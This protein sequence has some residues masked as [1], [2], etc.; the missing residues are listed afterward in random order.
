[1]QKP[2]EFSANQNSH[3]TISERRFGSH[4]KLPS[5]ATIPLGFSRPAQ[6]TEAVMARKPVSVAKK[7]CELSDWKR[8][9]C[10]NT[11]AV[12]YAE[13]RD[14]DRAVKC[15][16]QALND[17]SIATKERAEREKFREEFWEHFW[18][19][20]VIVPLLNQLSN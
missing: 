17:S 7:V 4:P 6:K 16:K 14:F 2:A 15:E 18:S 19:P 9:G 20:A 8:S 1:M 12:A 5:L 13:A 10:Y 11:V 3:C